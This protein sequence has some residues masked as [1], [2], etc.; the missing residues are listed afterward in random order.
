[1]RVLIAEDDNTTAMLL[2]RVL[3][4]AGHEVVRASDGRLALKMLEDARSFD[5]ILTDWLMPN[6]DG[7]AFVQAVRSRPGEAPP[8]VVVTQAVSDEARDLVLEAGADYYLAKPVHPQELLSCVDSMVRNK[9]SRLDDLSRPSLAVPVPKGKLTAPLVLLTAGTGGPMALQKIFRQLRV[10]RGASF[11]IVQQGP[12]WMLEALAQRLQSQTRLH[13][14]LAV[15]GEPVL[16]GQVRVAPGDKHCVLDDSSDVL[17][18]LDTG[19]VN[20][21]KPAADVL[22]RSAGRVGPQCLAVVLSGMGCDGTMG[23]LV[24]GATGGHLVVQ[25]PRTAEVAS[26]PH[27]ACEHGRPIAIAPIEQLAIILDGLILGLEKTHA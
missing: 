21:L 9:H 19:P 6:M 8:I 22:F 20:N 23:A 17:R 5:V 1:M 2:T 13:V 27:V 15:D 10:G 3:T 7:I 26:M 11:V 14:A 16:P 12:N 18:L 24:L 25:D 4:N